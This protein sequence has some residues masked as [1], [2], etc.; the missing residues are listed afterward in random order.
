M[1]SATKSKHRASLLKPMINTFWP[2]LVILAIYI[3]FSELVLR[4]IHP[5]L[6]GGMLEYFRPGSTV[7]KQEA[8]WYAGGMVACNFVNTLLANQYMLDC[9]HLGM[10]LRVAA[11]ALIYKKVS[12]C[13]L[14]FSLVN[15]FKLNLNYLLRSYL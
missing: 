10:K 15:Q 6:L 3:F 11:C 1:K 4:L 14:S 5:P 2:Q 12:L 13:L 8:L 7:S 9:F